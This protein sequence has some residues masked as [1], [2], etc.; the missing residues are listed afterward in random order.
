M[1]KILL[2]VAALVAAALEPSLALAQGGCPTFS[3]G[4]V[5]TAGQW[6]VCFDSK[7]NILGF[8][9]VNKAGDTMLGS[10]VTVASTA[11]ATGFNVPQ[12]VAPSAPNNGDVWATASGLFVQIAGTTYNVITGGGG[13]GSVSSVALAMPGI[14]SVSGSPVTGAGTLTA[15]LVN[16]SANLVFSGPSSGGG[17]AP[18]FRSLVAADLPSNQKAAAIEFAISDGNGGAIMAGLKGFVEVPFACSIAHVALVSDVSGSVVIDIWKVAFAGVPATSGNSITASDKPTLASAQKYFDTS[19]TG[20]TT[21]VSAGDWL[22]FNVDSAT[23]VT[24]VTV[25]LLCNRT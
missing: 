14:F 12:G 18:T 17:A 5:L 22:Y 1:R 2:A 9:P 16:Q 11:A 23:T 25:S 13:G 24:K 21:T 3:Y 7:Q 19:L 4:L 15:A 8:L 20:W 6:Q 10:L